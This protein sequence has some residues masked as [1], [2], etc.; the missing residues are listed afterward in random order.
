VTTQICFARR[1]GLFNHPRY[2]QMR[3]NAFGATPFIS[4]LQVLA[5]RVPSF[6]SYPFNIPAIAALKERLSLHPRATYFVGENGTGKSTLIEALAVAA[7]FNAEG[8]SANFQFATRSSESELHRCVRLVRTSRRPQ[9]GFFLRA[10]S[11]FN[12]AT[13]IEEMDRI[14]ALAPPVIDS[15]G[16]RSLHEQ[17]HG[18][19]FMALVE[20][21]FGPS[22][23]YILDEPEAALSI[24]RQIE[25]LRKLHTHVTEKGSQ[26]IVATHSPVL[27]ALPGAL[28]Y[29]LGKDGITEVAYEETD[30]FRLARDFLLDPAKALG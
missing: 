8:G 21:R 20:H 1:V 22:G 19:S 24:K 13:N 7:G 25:L 23:L 9:T 26:I 2:S 16:G 14:L 18:E 17:S 10:E 5:E 15:Y 29:R 11:F 30:A 27:M 28:I 12:L 4:S 3:A 6:D